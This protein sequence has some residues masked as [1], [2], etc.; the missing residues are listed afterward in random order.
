MSVIENKCQAWLYWTAHKDAVEQEILFS[1]T[2]SAFLATGGEKM[3][4]CLVYV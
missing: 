3:L 4:R 2:E 1:E